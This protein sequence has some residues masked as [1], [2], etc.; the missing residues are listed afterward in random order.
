MIGLALAADMAH[1]LDFAGGG[2]G[3]DGGLDAGELAGG[4]SGP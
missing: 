3:A 2:G 4:D 1:D